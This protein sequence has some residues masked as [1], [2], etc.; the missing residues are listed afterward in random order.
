MR[1]QAELAVAVLMSRLCSPSF[2]TYKRESSL[3]LPKGICGTTAE[4][5]GPLCILRGQELGSGSLGGASIT[6]EEIELE[7][8][9]TSKRED[10][11]LNVLVGLST[12]E[13]RVE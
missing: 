6:A 3:G 5:Y 2:R 12:A 10:V 9:V 7:N 1:R 13:S 11:G 8:D 4:D